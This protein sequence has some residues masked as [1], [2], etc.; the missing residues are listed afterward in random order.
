MGTVGTALY[1]FLTGQREYSLLVSLEPTV[2]FVIRPWSANVKAILS[3]ASLVRR[4]YFLHGKNRIDNLLT[5]VCVV[6][7]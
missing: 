4:I 1:Y 5:G 3:M 2:A 6:I 7:T